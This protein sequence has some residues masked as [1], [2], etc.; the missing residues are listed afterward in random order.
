MNQFNSC[1]DK[2]ISFILKSIDYSFAGS[3]V[4]KRKEYEDHLRMCAY[5][6]EQRAI[7]NRKKRIIGLGMAVGGIII[8]SVAFL[9]LFFESERIGR[10]SS[11]AILFGLGLFIKGVLQFIRGKSFEQK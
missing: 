9:P 4:E 1:I 8:V 10:A 11:I 3:S 6:R 2:K 5:C 7:I